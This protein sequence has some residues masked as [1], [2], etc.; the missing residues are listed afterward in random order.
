MNRMKNNRIGFIIALIVPLL[1]LI[2]LTVKP[3]WTL[4]YG[5]DV[6]L[7][8]VPIAPSDLLYGDYVTLRYEI[9]EVPK[10][11]I[12]TAILKKI[13]N[14]SN[15]NELTVY[16]IL[17]EQGDVY[18]LSSLSD[19]K[20]TDSVYLTGKLSVYDYQNAD[21]INVHSINFGLDRYYIPENTGKELKDLS[22]KGQ[23]MAHIKVKNG[24][25]ILK[26]ITA[27]K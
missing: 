10:N 6:A 23:L 12:S 17:I 14:R 2:G 9:E 18:V 24:Y 8:T 21:G 3:L 7:L 22:A 4:T 25:G 15:S 1:L 13:D 27:V 11:E 20:P 5:D 19:K 26:E 16:G